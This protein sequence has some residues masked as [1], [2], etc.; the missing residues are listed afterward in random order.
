MARYVVGD[1]QGCYEGLRRL[2]DKVEFDP[3]YDKLWAVG[4]LI[5][6]GPDSLKTLTYLKGLKDSFE[7][8]LGNHDLHFIA[9][10]AGVKTAKSNDFLVPLLKSKRAEEF[11]VWLRQKP[12][13]IRIDKNTLISHAGLYPQW[14]FK[15][16]VKLSDEIQLCLTHD[17]WLELIQ[18]MYGSSPQY[19]DSEMSGFNRYRFIINAFTRMRF[20]RDNA[21]L[22]FDTKSAPNT[23]SG[24]LSPWFNVANAR[25]KKQH[26]VIFGH[27][28]TL[29]GQ[30]MSPQFIGL[31]TGYVWG[32]SM[33]LLNLDNQKR[34]SIRNK[35]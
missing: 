1:I 30:T 25:L 31:D 5:A 15:K 29:M 10:Q 11:S 23:Y 2:L 22:E 8:V 19:W 16:A 28:A 3:K 20:I 21:T 4:D 27:W 14:S 24:P 7:T 32:N 12:L 35:G 13:A 18:N 17:D 26:T 6:R 34:I 9:I 33:T